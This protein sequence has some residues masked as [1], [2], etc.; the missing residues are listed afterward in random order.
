MKV[1]DHPDSEYDLV[2]VVGV[3]DPRQT[4]EERIELLR[5]AIIRRERRIEWTIQTGDLSGERQ[6][7]AQLEHEI[8]LYKAEISTLQSRTPTD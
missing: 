4:V 1:A 3:E 5:H 8:A 7:I 2:H 6:G